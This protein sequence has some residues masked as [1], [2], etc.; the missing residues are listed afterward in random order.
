M[1]IGSPQ[2]EHGS[3]R[4]SGT[5]KRLLHFPLDRVVG[6]DEVGA[7]YEQEKVGCFQFPFDLGV[8]F[9]ASQAPLASFHEIL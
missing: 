7:D 9:T 2:Q 5:I 8:Q 4:V 1:R 6:R 3:R